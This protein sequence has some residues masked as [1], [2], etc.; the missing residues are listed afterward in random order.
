MQKQGA[1]CNNVHTEMV[2]RLIQTIK[3][4]RIKPEKVFQLRLENL[5]NEIEKTDENF[6]RTK[7]NFENLLNYIKNS[8][9]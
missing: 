4:G 9:Y 6:K 1:L 5:K 8:V 3:N 7:N 2:S